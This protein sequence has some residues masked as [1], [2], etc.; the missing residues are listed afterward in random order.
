MNVVM[1]PRP[2]VSQGMSWF[3][4]SNTSARE[5]SLF[6]SMLYGCYYVYTLVSALRTDVA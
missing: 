4:V 6:Q 1:L 2:S 5:D 3:T